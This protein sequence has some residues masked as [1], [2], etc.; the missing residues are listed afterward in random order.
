MFLIH[1]ELGYP[2]DKTD[3]LAKMNMRLHQSVLRKRVENGGNIPQ[4]LLG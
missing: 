4:E 2:R 1:R 3:D